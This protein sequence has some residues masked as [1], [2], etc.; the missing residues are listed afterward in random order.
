[1]KKI[2]IVAA[3]CAALA[4]SAVAIYAGGFRCQFCGGS[5]WAG[6]NGNTSCSVCKGTGR[7]SDY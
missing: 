1:M 4:G 7:N 5:G 2:M 6:G 3:V